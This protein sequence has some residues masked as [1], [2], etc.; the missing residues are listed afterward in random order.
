MGWMLGIV[1][2]LGLVGWNR[3]GQTRTGVGKGL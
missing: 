1:E 3:V 2:R